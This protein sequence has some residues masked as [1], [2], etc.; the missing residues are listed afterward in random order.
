M[1]DFVDLYR[2]YLRAM[3]LTHDEKGVSEDVYEAV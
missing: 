2:S 3:T 1:A